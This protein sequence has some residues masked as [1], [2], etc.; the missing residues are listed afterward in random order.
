MSF[1]AQ[2][3]DELSR[4][5]GTCPECAYAQ[6]SAIIR[7]CGTLS[8]KGSGRYALRVATETGAVARTMIKVT[9]ELFDLDTPLV[10]RRSNLHKTRNY[11]IQIPEQGELEGALV[12]LGILV[13][14][15]GI[16]PG[17]PEWLVA[18][19]CCERAFLRG[20][21]MAGG[22]IANPTGDFHLEIAVSGEAY[23]QAI[24]EACAH[25]GVGARLNRRRG[26]WVVY[27]KSYRD[28]SALLVAMGGMRSATAAERVRA[29]K[30]QKNDVNRRVNAEMANQARSSGAAVD[31]LDL[32]A[33]IEETGGLEGLSPALAEFCRLR[34]AHPELSLVALGRLCDPPVGKSA[35]HHRVRRLQEGLEARGAR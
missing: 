14:G 9:H 6:L 1:T 27:V 20:T 25:V 34:R 18:R 4:V 8:F 17:V 23:A 10:V 35:M 7:V 3:K 24:I 31:Q 29:M 5:E 19:P 12:R 11:L 15:Q 16:V 13:P 33:R 28:I 32:I 21:F 2:V 22:F 30:S 26:L